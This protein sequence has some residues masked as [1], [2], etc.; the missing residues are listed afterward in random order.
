ML[1]KGFS[2]AVKQP[3]HLND[4]VMGKLSLKPLN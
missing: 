4:F 1:F 3:S 2:V